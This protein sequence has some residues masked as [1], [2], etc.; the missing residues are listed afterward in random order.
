MTIENIILERN[1]RGM[2]MDW[3]KRIVLVFLLMGFCGKGLFAGRR[4]TSMKKVVALKGTQRPKRRAAKVAEERIQEELDLDDVG[5]KDNNS[6][7]SGSPKDSDF[8]VDYAAAEECFKEPLRSGICMFCSKPENNKKLLY[9]SPECEEC[10]HY[11]H[12]ECW[13]AMQGKCGLCWRNACSATEL[14]L[15]VGGMRRTYMLIPKEN[16][17]IR[18]YF[19]TKKRQENIERFNDFIESF[20]NVGD[21]TPISL[22]D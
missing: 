17:T 11:A 2:Y 19:L 9:F 22:F 7:C 15:G 12:K 8:F 1:E 4:A 21:L 20:K 5:E 13:E 3:M 18:G 14:T 16:E 6:E 10:D